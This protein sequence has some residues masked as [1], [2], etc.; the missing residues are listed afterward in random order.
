MIEDWVVAG[1]EAPRRPSRHVVS[2][3]DSYH[4]R[5][6]HVCSAA[7][8]SLRYYITTPRGVLGLLSFKPR[9]ANGLRGLETASRQAAHPLGEEVAS[10]QQR[11]LLLLP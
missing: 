5:V 2:D 8:F 1:A 6:F 11:V 3:G 4:A 9:L 7:S 10:F